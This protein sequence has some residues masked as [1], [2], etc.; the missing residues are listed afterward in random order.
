MAQKG[1][2]GR[3]KRKKVTTKGWTVINYERTRWDSVASK[4]G[5]KRWL[6]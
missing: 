2:L 5:I 3:W 4:A 6:C 1:L